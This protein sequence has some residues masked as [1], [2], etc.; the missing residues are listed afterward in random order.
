VSSAAQFFPAEAYH[1]NFFDL[2]PNNPYIV[3]NDLPKLD[4]LKSTFPG[5]YRG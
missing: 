1:Q 3:Q 4:A 5:L 2:H